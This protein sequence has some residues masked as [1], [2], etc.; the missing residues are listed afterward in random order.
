MA[1]WT[2]AAE[3]RGIELNGT[4]QERLEAMEKS[5]SL[6]AAMVDWKEEPCQVFRVQEDPQ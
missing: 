4:Q 1:D 3:A 5:I 2:K 6:L